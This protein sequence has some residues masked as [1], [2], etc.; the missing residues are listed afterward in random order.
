LQRFVRWFRLDQLEEVFGI[1]NSFYRGSTHEV[2]VIRRRV[3]Q[4]AVLCVIYAAVPLWAADFSNYRGFQLGV[5][6]TTAL[7]QAGMKLSDVRLVHQRPA[8]IQE[9]EWRPG[10]QYGADAKRVD[11]VREGLLRFYNGELF[12]IITTYD[13]Q[14]VEGMTEADM[15]EAISVVYGNATKPGG[16]ISYHSNYGEVAPVLARWGNAEYSHDLIRTGDRT[17]FA[18]ILSLKRLDVLA[19]AAI[20]EAGRL[21]AVEAPQR[22]IDLQEQQEAEHRLGLDKARSVNKPNFR[23]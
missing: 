14:R 2:K 8:R 19:Q 15:V 22:A 3:S 7:K 12:Q 1:D 10:F 11:P 6:V 21:D 5:D 20:A 18:L 4:A 13:R 17:S 9:L 23:P 16:E